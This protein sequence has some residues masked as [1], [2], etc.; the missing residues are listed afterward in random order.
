MALRG[1]RRVSHYGK[2]RAP[3]ESQLMRLVT[4]LTCAALIIPAT[5]FAQAGSTGGTLGKT[6]KSI[7]GG[8]EQSEPRRVPESKR[9]A[10]SA[11]A[12]EKPTGN[13]CQ[14]IVGRWA[15]HY[16]TGTTETVFSR[17]GTGQ[18]A[19]TGLTNT[20][21]CEDG[22]ATIKWSHGYT[23]RATI[24]RDGNSLSISSSGQSFSATRN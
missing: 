4:V 6:D 7:S 19:P 2:L 8:E 5:V 1:L 10:R 12:K 24:S 3:L 23:D 18:N 22:I 14:K 11:V 21:T 17:G 15:W 9:P 16:W 13:S 20:W